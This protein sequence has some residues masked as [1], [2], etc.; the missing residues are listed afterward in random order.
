MTVIIIRKTGPSAE[1]VILMI[2]KSAISHFHAFGLSK[3]YRTSWSRIED[4]SLNNIVIVPKEE[5]LKELS[6]DY[7]NMK[8]MIFDNKPSFEEIIEG[9]SQLEKFFNNNCV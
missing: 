3:Y 7:N 2:E 8:E 4:C 9:L 1:P 6:D 5:R